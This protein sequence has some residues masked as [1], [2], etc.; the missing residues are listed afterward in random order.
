MFTSFDLEKGE[1]FYTF[2]KCIEMGTN[3]HD[4]ILY[5]LICYIS[6]LPHFILI[7]S[8]KTLTNMASK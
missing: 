7:M 2:D 8:D 3:E 5:T 4:Q 1:H 6:F